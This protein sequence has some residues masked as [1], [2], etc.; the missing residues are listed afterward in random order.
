VDWCLRVHQVQEVSVVVNKSMPLASGLCSGGG[1]AVGTRL[2]VL[3]LVVPPV[4]V[5]VLPLDPDLHWDYP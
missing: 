2:V 3:G 5:L 1:S 4:T